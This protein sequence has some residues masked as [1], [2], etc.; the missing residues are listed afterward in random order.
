[1]LLESS[2]SLTAVGA[3]VPALHRAGTFLRRLVY[4]HR[5]RPLWIATAQAAPGNVL[6]TPLSP[7]ADLIRVRGVEG[8]LYRRT[9]EIRDAQWELTGFVSPTTADAA[10]AALRAAGH[11]TDLAT[12]A[13]LLEVALRAALAG[14]PHADRRDN[15]SWS[16]GADLDTEA[17]TLLAVN[18]LRDDDTVRAIAG[19]VIHNET[20]ADDVADVMTDQV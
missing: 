2:L 19:S 8:R 20:R 17:R 15:A 13:L 14:L 18:R 4:H 11:D 1:M 7:L 5:L 10:T 12:E 9:I 3:L 16:G 6:G